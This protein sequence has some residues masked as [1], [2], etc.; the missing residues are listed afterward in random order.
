KPAMTG[1]TNRK[2]IVVPWIVNSSLNVCGVSRLLFAWLSWRRII[3]ASTPPSTKK[4]KVV[5]RYMIPIFL[6]SVVVTHD[7]QPRASGLT[8]W[9]TIWGT[10]AEIWVVAMV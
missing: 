9:A 6:W 2:I 8:W 10:G 1:T 5:T 3:S 7:T 4:T